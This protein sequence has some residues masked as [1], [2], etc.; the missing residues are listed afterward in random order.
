MAFPAKPSSSFVFPL[1]NRSL[2][3][4]GYFLK[5]RFEEKVQCD[6]TQFLAGTQRRIEDPGDEVEFPVFSAASQLH[7]VGHIGHQELLRP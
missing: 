7:R 1:G 4:P 3:N 2:F 6:H 5:G